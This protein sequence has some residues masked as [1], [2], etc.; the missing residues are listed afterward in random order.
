MP[1]QSSPPPS[2]AALRKATELGQRAVDK[3]DKA[4]SVDWGEL[5]K[6]FLALGLAVLQNVGPAL[7]DVASRKITERVERL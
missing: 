6:V 1:D 7:V 5:G 3:L 4:E 2:L